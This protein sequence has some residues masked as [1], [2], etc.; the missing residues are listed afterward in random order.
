M[1]TPRILALIIGLLFLGFGLSMRMSPQ[2]WDGQRVLASE[3]L[4]K[5]GLTLLSVWLAWPAIE[6]I[7]K[8]PGGAILLVACTAS[9]GLFL[10]RPKTILFTAPFLA[11]A[12]AVAYARQ[13]LSRPPKR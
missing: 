11:I 6:S 13:W 7:R 4:N 1:P 12:I 9:F 8:T 5:V 3:P 10:F 2:M